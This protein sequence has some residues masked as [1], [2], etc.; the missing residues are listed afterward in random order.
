MTCCVSIMRREQL[1]PPQTARVVLV[2]GWSA[3]LPWKNRT[4][5]S[6]EHRPGARSPDVTVIVINL[7]H[8][9]VATSI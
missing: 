1:L 2:C 8:R 3:K 7:L 5:S 4:E 9:P 6:M